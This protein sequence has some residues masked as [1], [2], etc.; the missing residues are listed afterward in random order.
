[1]RNIMGA[2][3]PSLGLHAKNLQVNNNSETL[4]KFQSFA[5]SFRSKA[6][7]VVLPNIC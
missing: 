5:I 1:L 2:G 7:L 3:W 4:N 6:I